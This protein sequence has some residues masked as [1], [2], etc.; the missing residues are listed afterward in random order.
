MLRSTE[1]S[2]KSRERRHYLEGPGIAMNSRQRPR[3]LIVEPEWSGHRMVLYTRIIVEAV[4]RRGWTPRLLTTRAARAQPAFKAVQAVLGGDDTV[5]EMPEVVYPGA[6]AGSLALMRWQWQV[7]ASM[8]EGFAQLAVDWQPDAVF[9]VTL[10]Y[11]GKIMPFMGSPFGSTPFAG[12]LLHSGGNNIRGQTANVVQRSRS[13]ASRALLRG[14]LRTRHLHCALTIDEDLANGW[15]AARLRFLPDVAWSR[16][17]SQNV[18]H[19][20]KRFVILAYGAL[21]ARKGIAQLLKAM[22]HEAAPS[23]AS[24]VLAG[25]PDEAVRDLLDGPDARRLRQAGRLVEV[26]RFVTDTEERELF[27]TAD[28]VWLG[29]TDFVGMSGVLLRAGASRRPVLACR[30][31]LIGR[32]TAAHRC[33]ITVDPVCASEVAAAMYTLFSDDDLRRTYGEN[34]WLVSQSHTP[35]NFG[36][37]ICD[38]LAAAMGSIANAPE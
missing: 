5:G 8:R 11:V 33:G 4:H 34:G 24:L 14:L 20:S 17:A 30:A 7:H 31:G 3:V 1:A 36:L 16:N 27:E 12:I 13:F 9:V 15:N 37:I 10:D 23:T 21:S 6:S 2:R 32:H 25:E 26:L 28:V 18:Q 29:Y 38:V 22:L 35:D 19:S